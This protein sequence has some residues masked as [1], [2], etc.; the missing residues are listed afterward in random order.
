MIRSGSSSLS[1]RCATR[2]GQRGNA[3]IEFALVMVLLLSFLFGI[4]EFSRALYAY[5]FVSHAAREATRFAMVR[6]KGWP[7]ACAGSSLAAN[8][9]AQ[10][11]DVTTFVQSILPGGLP[12]GTVTT[13]NPSTVASCATSNTATTLIVCTA[14]PSTEA[15]SVGCPPETP[16]CLVEVQV[17]Y[18]FQFMF[19]F[20]PTSVLQLKSASEVSISQ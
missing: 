8:C 6:G 2:A 11:S 1:S 3:T 13:S 9:H 20:L 14:W 18:N 12:V 15:N 19:P 17:Q 4:M 16:G 5:H 10:A 7:A